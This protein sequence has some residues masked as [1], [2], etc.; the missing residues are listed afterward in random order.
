MARAANNRYYTKFPAWI[1]VSVGLTGVAGERKVNPTPEYPYPVKIV[2]GSTDA[3]TSQGTFSL[4]AQSAPGTTG[5]AR[6]PGDIPLLALFGKR[7][8][9][10]PRRNWPPRWELARNQKL[11]TDVLNVGGESRKHLVFA[12]EPL[13]VEEQDMPMEQVSGQNM[14]VFTVDMDLTGAAEEIVS[15]PMSSLTSDLLIIGAFTDTSAA[16][17]GVRVT[18]H[19][20]RTWCPNSEFVPVWAMAGRGAGDLPVMM[21]HEPY[22]LPKQEVMKLSFRNAVLADTPESN[23]SITFVALQLPT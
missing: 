10:E 11:R 20:G 22:F 6:S 16:S 23:G 2:G 21:W 4:I 5:P 9:A 8:G 12:C 17:I 7:D 1:P 19:L 18:D 15:P 14:F 13:G 3:V